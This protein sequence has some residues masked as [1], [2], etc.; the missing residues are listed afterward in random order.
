MSWRGPFWNL[1]NS[2][3]LWTIWMKEHYLRGQIQATA[4]TLDSGTWK[5]LVE[6]KGTALD[7]MRMHASGTG[8]ESWSWQHRKMRCFL[9][10]LAGQL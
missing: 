4:I 2:K 3:S 6:V 8:D 5:W 7:H 10:P 1:A 9:S